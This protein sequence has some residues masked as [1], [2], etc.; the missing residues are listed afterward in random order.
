MIH[1]EHCIRI[2]KWK[3]TATD[4]CYC[5]W[6]RNMTVKSGQRR[7]NPAPL[8]LESL[9]YLLI[10]DRS[11]SSV[12]TNCWYLSNTKCRPFCIGYFFSSSRHGTC[13]KKKVITNKSY[14]KR[15]GIRWSCWNSVSLL[16][17]YT[18]FYCPAYDGVTCNVHH[19]S[20]WH[21]RYWFY[22]QR[23]APST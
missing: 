6:Y 22:V 14:R 2:Y 21:A 7:W 13:F 16:G 9:S 20:N 12:N 17:L 10:P 3:V 4:Y 1:T 11:Y 5:Y 18:C 23:S 8:E 19:S 15:P